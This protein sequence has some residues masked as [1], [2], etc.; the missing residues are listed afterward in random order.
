[1]ENPLSDPPSTNVLKSRQT[2][3]EIIM[4]MA[5]I[6][7]QEKV[8]SIIY[9]NVKHFSAKPFCF[10]VNNNVVNQF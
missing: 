3:A 9:T 4:V 6:S 10:N 1:M 2:A 5:C 8:T 7:A